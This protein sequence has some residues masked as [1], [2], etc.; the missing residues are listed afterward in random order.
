MQDQLNFFAKIST[1]DK[2]K[3]CNI[4][5][6]TNNNELP[7]LHVTQILE[8]VTSK[9]KI[10]GGSQTNGMWSKRPSADCRTLD[11]MEL[12]AGLTPRLM[13]NCGLPPLERVPSLFPIYQAS[14]TS[15]MSPAVSPCISQAIL[16]KQRP[17]WGRPVAE[18]PQPHNTMWDR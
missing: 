5:K 8:T 10:M 1:G 6:K 2:N 18:G 13:T 12:R 4:N 9:K 17:V 3:K 14:P 11:P 7:L 16:G 15:R